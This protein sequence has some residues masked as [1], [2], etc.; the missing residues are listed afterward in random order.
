MAMRTT[1]RF[2]VSIATRRMAATGGVVEARHAGKIEAT[3]VTPTPMTIELTIV[4]V[5]MT[6]AVEGT[7][8]PAASSRARSPTARPMP[9]SNPSSDATIPT[10]SA[11]R[12][13]EPSTWLRLAPMARSSATSRV[14]WATMIEKV[15]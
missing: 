1:D 5:E 2:E 10:A 12:K 7:P 4:V 11:S 8:M 13:I 3:S 6:G 9:A 14:R 15:L